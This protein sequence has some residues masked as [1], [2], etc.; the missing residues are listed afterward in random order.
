MLSAPGKQSPGDRLSC[1]LPELGQLVLPKLGQLLLPGLGQLLMPEPGQL[2]LPELGQPVLPKLGFPPQLLALSS[3]PTRS[4]GRR[5]L[6]SPSW[7]HLFTVSIY[8]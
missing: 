6:P 3:C 2:L 4:T 1:Q 7:D 5:R 8:H